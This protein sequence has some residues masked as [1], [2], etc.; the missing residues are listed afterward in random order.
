[1]FI[2]DNYFPTV[3]ARLSYPEC[4]DLSTSSNTTEA[5]YVYT[6]FLNTHT[7]QYFRLGPENFYSSNELYLRVSL[8]SFVCLIGD[9]RYW[10]VYRHPSLYPQFKSMY[11]LARY[12]V[13]TTKERPGTGDNCK[14][15]LKAGDTI[16]FKFNQPCGK[17]VPNQ[18]TNIYIS[19]APAS[20]DDNMPCSGKMGEFKK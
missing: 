7:V 17:M 3:G 10:F 14:S 16:E 8:P 6:G 2:S 20:I 4:K 11:G 19:V 1:M 12:C 9:Y 13:S 15:A 18:C 5:K